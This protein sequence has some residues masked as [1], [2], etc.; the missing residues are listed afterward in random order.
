MKGTMK[1]EDED[2]IIK[3]VSNTFDKYAEEQRKN[4]HLLA[5]IVDLR[6]ELAAYKEK[7]VMLHEMR[8]E[9]GGL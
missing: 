3:I 5:R 1:Q 7:E 9:Q 8:V 6:I 4:V 2:K